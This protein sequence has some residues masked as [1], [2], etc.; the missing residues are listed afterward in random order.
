MYSTVFDSSLIIAIIAINMTVIGLTSLAEMKNVIG[1]D[2]G[3]FLL[4]KYKIF[5]FIRVYYL[6]IVF[7][8]INV[9]SLFLL[10]VQNYQFRLIHF[11]VLIVSLIFA[12][13]YFFTYII[14]ESK[15]VKKQIYRQELLGHYYNSNQETTY[16]PDI[17]TKVCNGSRT[18]DKISGNVIHYFDT[19]STDSYEAFKE[20]FGP[21]SMIY[22]YTKRLNKKRQKKYKYNTKTSNYKQIKPYVYR[23]SINRTKEMSHE[24]FQM[25]RYSAIQD[26]WI[27]SALEL[28]ENNRFKEFDYIRLCN[29]TRVISQINTFGN[30]PNLYQ[31]KFIEHLFSYYKSAMFHNIPTNIPN[32]TK[33]EIQKLAEYTIVQLFT[34][35][36][37]TY[38]LKGNK[39]YKQTIESIIIKMLLSEKN[40]VTQKTVLNRLLFQTLEI[41]K[42][43]SIEQ[44]QDLFTSILFQYQ[45]KSQNQKLPKN[46][47][48]ELKSLVISNQNEQQNTANQLKLQIFG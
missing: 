41:G 8:S 5:G 10:A 21:N 22:T 35:M 31:H 15:G 4:R 18:T 23:V 28:F 27:L 38:I 47:I 11:W 34:F 14:V 17:I 7:A 24:F 26:K 36:L 42:T 9:A 16:E 37:N 44:L 3:K 48:K 45:V 39:L 32:E 1:I 12:I 40:L 46:L 30:S 25:Y 43:H 29:F 2:Y 33:K 6:L 19:Y 20:L 13:Y